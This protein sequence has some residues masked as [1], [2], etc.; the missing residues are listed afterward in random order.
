MK[1]GEGMNPYQ[2]LVAEYARLLS[3]GRKAP[4]GEFPDAPRPALPADAPRALFFSP[5]PDDEC[6]SGGLALRMM[7]ESGVRV[8]N[9]AV[10][11]GR[12][13]ERQEPRYR[14]LQAACRYLGFDLVQTAPAGLERITTQTREKEPEYWERCVRIIQA[15]L[16]EHKPRVLFFPHEHD[17]NSAHIGVHFLVMDALRIMPREFECFVVE[18]EFWGQMTDPN[19]LVEL[20]EKDL[21]DMVIATTFHVGEVKRNP[22]HLLLP[23]YMMDNVRR[24]GELVGGQGGA[25]PDFIFAAVFRLSKW[26]DSHLRRTFEGGKMLGCGQNPLSLLK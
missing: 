21:A 25:A 6:I 1:H 4:L 16:T 9:V 2:K 15:I 17:W 20:S 18:T 22:Y 5:H 10:T 26:S 24:G 3:D 14:E 8:I 23:P 19:L 7:R 12:I 11:Q 13:K